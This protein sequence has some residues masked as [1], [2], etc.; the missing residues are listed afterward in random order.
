[1]DRQAGTWT[2]VH[3]GTINQLFNRYLDPQES[4]NRLNV[5]WARFTPSGGGPALRVDTADEQLIAVSVYP[6]SQ[7]QI[8]LA[9]HS[10][11]LRQSQQTYINIDHRQMGLGGTNSW[12]ELPLPKYRLSPNE[13]YRWSFLL[14]PETVAATTKAALPRLQTPAAPTAPGIVVPPLPSIP[15]P[16]SNQQPTPAP[17]E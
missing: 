1:V 10:S 3:S 16:P 9:R 7:D 13:V 11:D 12:G 6:V 14:S 8:Q 4:G 17:T 5:R 2:T 15:S